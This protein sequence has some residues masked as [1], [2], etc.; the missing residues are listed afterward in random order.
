ME[1]RE[2]VLGR[3]LVGPLRNPQQREQA[4]LPPEDVVPLPM[5]IELNAEHA[6]GLVGA[7]DRLRSVWVEVHPG[8]TPRAA[9]TA[10][11]H[12][13]MSVADAAALAWR[14]YTSADAANRAINRIWPDLPIQPQSTYRSAAAAA[15]ALAARRSYSAFGQGIVWALIDSGIE[16]SH[17]HFVTHDTFGSE[18]AP[19]HRSFVGETSEDPLIDEFGHGTHN[20]GIIAGGLPKE[21]PS[22][23]KLTVAEGVRDALAPSESKYVPVSAEPELL[24]G[25]APHCKLVSCKVLDAKG[26]GRLSNIIRALTYIRE[27][28][29]DGRILRVHGVTISAGYEYDPQMFGC[30]H[31][32]MCV[33]VDRLVRSGVVVVAPAGNTGF[34]TVAAHMRTTQT[35]LLM[36]INDPGNAALAI[37]VGSTHRDSPHS[38]GV[39]YFSSKGPT[40]DGRLKPDLVAPGE[41][42]MSCAAGEMLTRLMGRGAHR[43]RGAARG[44]RARHQ[45]GAPADEIIYFEQT[46]TS[47]ASAYVSGAIA[48]FLSV[49]REF[50][51]RPEEVKRIF[52]ETATSLGRETYFQGRGMVNLLQ[53]LQAV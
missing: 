11:Y 39:S 42:I 44:A 2:S 24:A 7:A 5:L 40:A 12:V 52:L 6:G 48:A 31:S 17:Q 37:T 34:G 18:V 19:L 27:E 53:A 38:Y 46:G 25:V 4:A 16:A 20:A 49:H 45:E 41:R 36:T 21:L 26:A 10:Y 13:E 30:G 1:D 50:I 22:G 8:A 47:A 3:I 9:S 35:G 32:P 15:S 14:D 51:G 43:A 23:L 29:N 33:E 28:L